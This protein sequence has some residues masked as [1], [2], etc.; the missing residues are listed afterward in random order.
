MITQNIFPVVDILGTDQSLL[1]GSAGYLHI[2]LLLEDAYGEAICSKEPDKF[3]MK[4]WDQI[5]K[6]VGHIASHCI[7][8]NRLMSVI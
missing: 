3:Q 6:V 7:Y 4:L 1:S 5:T 8:K 2:L